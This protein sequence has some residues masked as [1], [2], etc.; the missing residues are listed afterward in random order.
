MPFEGGGGV[1][2]LYKPYLAANFHVTPEES[3]Y[4]TIPPYRSTVSPRV[5]KIPSKC[6]EH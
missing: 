4:D 1:R 3:M 5:Q 6:R 2:P